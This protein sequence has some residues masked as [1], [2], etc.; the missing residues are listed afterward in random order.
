[1]ASGQGSHWFIES[2]TIV[3]LCITCPSEIFV[4]FVLKHIHS[5]IFTQSVDKLFHSFI[6]LCEKAYYVI[7]NLH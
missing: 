7:S 1:M 4:N 3:H 5:K 2:S 6:V